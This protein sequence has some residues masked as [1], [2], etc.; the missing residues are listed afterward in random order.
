MVLGWFWVILGLLGRLLGWSWAAMGRL[1]DPTE[2]KQICWCQKV[3]KKKKGRPLEA[4]SVVRIE[5]PTEL[6]QI[7][8]GQKVETKRSLLRPLVS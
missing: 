6:S 2:L 8:W 1:M 4:T 5:N 7:C 3:K